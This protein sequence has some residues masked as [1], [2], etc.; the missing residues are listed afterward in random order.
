MFPALWKYNLKNCQPPLERRDVER[1]ARSIGR[2]RSGDVEF[3]AY[4]TGTRTGQIVPD[5]QH[6]IRLALEKLGLSF[7]YNDFAS[8]ALV[9]FHGNEQPLDDIV[10]NRTW[11]LLDEAFGFRP[12]IEFFQIVV[13]DLARRQSFHPVREYLAGLTWDQTSRIDTWLSA[14]GGAADTPY[15]RAVGALFLISAVRRVRFPGSKFDE[16]LILESRQGTLKSQALRTLCPQEDWFSDDLPLGVDAK[17]IIERTAGKWLIEASEL[18]GYTNSEIER[19]KG[20]LS[21]QVDGPVRLA[22]ARIPSEVRRQFVFAG[23]TN[24]MTE[25]LRDSTGNRRFWPVRVSQFDLRKLTR[26]RD[27]LWAEAAYREAIGES[28]RLPEELWPA[29]AA[30]QDA[31]RQVDPWEEI[32]DDRLPGGF[33][34]NAIAVTELWAALGEAAKYF[35]RND[36]ER[37]AKIMQRRGFTR[38]KKVDV[39]LV[40]GRARKDGNRQWAWVRDGKDPSSLEIRMREPEQEGMPF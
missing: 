39:V 38:K 12:P 10:L 3:I 29:A 31:R 21:R 14:Y 37:V 26:D 6:N 33:E 20:M 25:Y 35:K 2:K 7:R 19:L 18:Q 34:R 27:Q 4:T 13:G 9:S 11:L 28:T 22:Y 1:I 36:A 40:Q 16:L 15:V 30:E 24:E 8:L 32:L 5:N 17:Q 23:T